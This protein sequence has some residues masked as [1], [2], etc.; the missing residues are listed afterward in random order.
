[1][2]YKTRFHTYVNVS[3]PANVVCQ[4][5]GVEHSVPFDLEEV[6][7]NSETHKRSNQKWKNMIKN[8]K[9]KKSNYLQIK[10]RLRN[11][12]VQRTGV[13]THN[14]TNRLRCVS[15]CVYMWKCG[16][17]HL[18]ETLYVYA[19]NKQKNECTMCS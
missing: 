16:C 14:H 9:W 11:N 13:N 19:S 17:D 7:H 4:S 6:S 10:Q 2:W 1:M 12:D 18:R 3:K 15:T 8:I 5:N